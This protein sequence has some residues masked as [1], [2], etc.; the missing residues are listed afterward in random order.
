MKPWERGLFGRLRHDAS[1]VWKSYI[2]APF[3]RALGDGSL[4]REDFRAYLVQDYLY[5]NHF[6]RAYALAAYKAPDLAG[7]RRAARSMSTIVDVEAALHVSLCAEWG[8]T[9]AEMAATPETLATLA[10]TRFLIERGLS[11][12]ALDLMVAMSACVMGYAEIGDRLRERGAVEN[13]PY[14]SWINTYAGS[15]YQAI[16]EE[17]ADALDALGARLG[18]EARYEI[19]LAEFTTASRLEAAFWTGAA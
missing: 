13:H 12:D 7:M 6:A 14:A 1:V 2:D 10:Y 9:E 18:A 5:L 19:L 3:V 4:P 17:E 15:D 11:G 16:A 8:M